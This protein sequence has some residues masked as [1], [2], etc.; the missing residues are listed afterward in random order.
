MA[1]LSIQVGLLVGFDPY[2]RFQP[3]KLTGTTFSSGYARQIERAILYL[4]C[5]LITRTTNHLNLDSGI[6]V[7]FL[8]TGGSRDD[9]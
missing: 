1:V 6:S 4:H 2:H 9:A 8:S 3:D 5:Q 7:K